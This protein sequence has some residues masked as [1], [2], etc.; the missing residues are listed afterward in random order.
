[1]CVTV[2][3][4]QTTPPSFSCVSEALVSSFSSSLICCQI[5][6][7]FNLIVKSSLNPM[8]IGLNHMHIEDFLILLKIIWTT[9]LWTA[10]PLIVSENQLIFI[11][12]QCTSYICSTVMDLLCML[13]VL[14]WV[15][16]WL[17]QLDIRVWFY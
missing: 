6:N 2:T 1:M 5:R 3:I 16:C 8:Q 15:F 14:P 7:L 17:S 10:H 9:L 12:L 4:V 11:L 13:H